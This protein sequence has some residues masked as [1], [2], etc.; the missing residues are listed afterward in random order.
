MER[1][2]RKAPRRETRNL[3]SIRVLVAANNAPTRTTLSELLAESGYRVDAAASSVEAMD[4]LETGQ[5]S[6]V[7]CDL[8]G[9]STDACERVLGLA[10]RQCYQPA[11]A[12]LAVSFEGQPSINNDSEVWIDPAD[13]PDLLTDLSELIAGR[14]ARRAAIG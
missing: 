11:T 5:Y 9:E 6:L 12:R 10:R 14:A 1:P 7:L 4:L 13:M 8:Q 2:I 3:P